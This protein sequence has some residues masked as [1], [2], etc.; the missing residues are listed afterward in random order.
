MVGMQLEAEVAAQDVAAQVARCARLFQRRL[1]AL[2]H[3]ENLA[4]DVVVTHA[5]AHRKAG[6]DHAFNHDVGVE[7]QDV[8]VLAGPR[9]SLVGVAHQVLLTRN[10][11]GMKLHFS[12][13]ENQRPPD[14]AGRTP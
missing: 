9:L 2:V 14:R 12:P 7:H 1:K 5:D 10:W 6:N 8:A 13:V 11:R 4:V 3:L